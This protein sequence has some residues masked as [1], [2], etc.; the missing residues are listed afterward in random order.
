MCGNR[1]EQDVD[2]DPSLA[3][4]PR[5]EFLLG[6]GQER[7]ACLAGGLG[8]LPAPSIRVGSRLRELIQSF[9]TH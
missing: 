5:P 4:P 2:L 3:P 9:N 7:E 6:R 8:G 1:A